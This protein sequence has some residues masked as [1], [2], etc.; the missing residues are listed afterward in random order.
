[1]NM[2]NYKNDEAGKESEEQLDSKV[3]P[4]MR[5][6][7]ATVQ[8]I[9]FGQLKDKLA[10][11][12]SS[13]PSQDYKRLVGCIVN[14]LFGT[15]A[16]DKDSQEFARE[17]IEVVEEELRAMAGNFPDMV[18]ALTDTLRMQTLCDHEEGINSLPTLLRAREVG[19]MEIDR[20]VPLPS[21]FMIAVRKLGAT[22]GLLEP[23][24]PQDSASE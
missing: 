22:H 14:D 17:H 20:S 19:M 6:A 3:I 9:L 24:Q 7:V 5:E 11:K 8:L 16:Q 12:Y 13:W 1:M 15:P 10:D 21:T 2:E 23:I 4:V 18:P